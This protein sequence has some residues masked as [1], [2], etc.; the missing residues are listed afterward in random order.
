MHDLQ[1]ETDRIMLSVDDMLLAGEFEKCNKW[2][3]EIA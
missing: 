2:L 1:E 3:E